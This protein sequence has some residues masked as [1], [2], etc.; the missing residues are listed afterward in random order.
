MRVEASVKAVAKM[1]NRLYSIINL[2][3]A[4]YFSISYAFLAVVLEGN[5]Y[6]RG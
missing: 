6:N 5:V 1:D 4:I 2:T 3:L